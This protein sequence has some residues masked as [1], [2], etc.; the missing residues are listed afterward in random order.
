MVLNLSM[1]MVLGPCI[2]ADSKPRKRRTMEQALFRTC[3][4]FCGSADIEQVGLVRRG[5]VVASR[6]LLGLPV[7]LRNG[8]ET[9]S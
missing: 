6:N 3:S 5:L 2:F 1:I 4:G 8:E 7:I 9:L